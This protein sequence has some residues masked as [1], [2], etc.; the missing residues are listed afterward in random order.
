MEIKVTIPQ[1]TKGSVEPDLAKG[2]ELTVHIL[3]GK[4]IIL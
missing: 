1:S 2:M 4:R 3:G